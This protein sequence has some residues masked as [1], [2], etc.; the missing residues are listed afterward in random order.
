[1]SQTYRVQLFGGILDGKELILADPPKLLNI[2]ISLPAPAAFAS[3]NEKF[4]EAGIQVAVYNR[5][6]PKRGDPSVIIYTVAV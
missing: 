4:P 2:P 1:M 6:G 3:A 5:R